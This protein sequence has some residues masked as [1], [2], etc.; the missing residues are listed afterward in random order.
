MGKLLHDAILAAVRLEEAISRAAIQR[1]Q[2]PLVAQLQA[3][4]AK[5]FRSQGREVARQLRQRGLTEAAKQPP[6]DDQEDDAADPGIWSM[7]GPLGAAIDRALDATTDAIAG[8]I[9]RLTQ[10]AMQAGAQGAV[11]GVGA[12]I[13]FDLRDP[14]VKAYL[15]ANPVAQRVAKINQTTK[16]RLSYLVQ[17]GIEQGWSPGKL[18][19]AITDRFGEFAAGRPQEHIASRA[20][21]V[22]VTE[23]GEAHSAGTYLGARQLA[24]KGFAL[25]KSWSAVND[26]KTDPDICAA[27]AAQGWI[28]LEQ[29]FQSG[30]DHPL[31]HPGCRCVLLTRPAPAPPGG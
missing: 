31:G 17:E 25:E 20:H 19:N 15:D 27:N 4:M 22:A 9:E 18:A 21:L 28:P 23:I 12:G 5:A 13:G 16:D 1:A 3:H 2:A 24:G 11:E 14:H 29:P 26:A 10:K 8:P 7:A 6:E 30:D